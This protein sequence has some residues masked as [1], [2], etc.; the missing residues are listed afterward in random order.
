ML[1]RRSCSGLPYLH[2]ILELGNKR[3]AGD[4]FKEAALHLEGHRDNEGHEEQ[5]LEHEKCE[6]LESA[7]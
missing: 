4:E 5:H 6:D 3:V 7:C 1:L 2:A